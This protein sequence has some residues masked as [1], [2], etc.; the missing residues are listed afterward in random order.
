[1]FRFSAKAGKCFSTHR[2]TPSGFAVVGVN[3]ESHGLY[4]RPLLAWQKPSCS[5]PVNV[6]VLN[7]YDELWTNLPLLSTHIH[8][9]CKDFPCA[10]S[11]A[12]MLGV[13]DAG[14]GGGGNGVFT[15]VSVGETVD[16]FVGAVWI[17]MVARGMAVALGSAAVGLGA[18]DGLVT[19]L[20]I[21]GVAVTL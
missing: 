10:L 14:G 2:R 4:Q 9:S 15:C 7:L 17:T 1:M 3:E 5:T 12:Q 18:L 13:G 8:A 11:C 6:S 20:L 16:V 21:V 19:V